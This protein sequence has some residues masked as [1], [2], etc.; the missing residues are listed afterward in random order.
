MK[1]RGEHIRTRGFTLLELMIAT[2]I[3]V[4]IGGAALALFAQHQPLF[5]RQQNLCGIEHRHTQRRGANAARRCQCGEWLLH[6]RE[7][8]GLARGGHHRKQQPG[9][10]LQ[11][12]VD[13]YLFG[14]VFRSTEYHKRRSQYRRHRIPTTEHSR[15]ISPPIAF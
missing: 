1:A 15:V 9:D 5:T 2:A 10:G 13:L 7:H 6:R 4:V 12:R 14:D 8:S 11:H 3:F